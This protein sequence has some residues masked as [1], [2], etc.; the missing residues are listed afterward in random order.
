MLAHRLPNPLI[1]QTP[2]ETVSLVAGKAKPS[3]ARASG[4][5]FAC[6]SIADQDA[7]RWFIDKAFNKSLS[8]GRALHPE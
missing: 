7:L 4:G 6:R 2:P 8:A 3:G 5:I 1:I